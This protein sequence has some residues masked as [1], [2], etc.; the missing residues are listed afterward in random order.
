M[1][2]RALESLARAGAFDAIHANRAQIVGSADALIAYAQSVALDRAS[3]QESLFGGGAEAARPR[4]PKTAAWNPV[5]QL[6]EELSAVGFYLSGHPLDDMV[7][8]L[9]RHRTTFLVDALAAAAAGAEAFRMVGMVRRRQERSSA[10]GFIGTP[11]VRPNTSSLKPTISEA[12]A[13]RPI[14]STPSS[15]R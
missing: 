3:A 10:G 15:S 11:T 12:T 14:L 1:N 5:E 4:L 9:R 6:D 7:E 13:P 2:K 8:V